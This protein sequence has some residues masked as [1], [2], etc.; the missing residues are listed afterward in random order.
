M[1]TICIPLWDA[2]FFGKM[3]D[4]V[5]AAHRLFSYQKGEEAAVFHKALQAGLLGKQIV[6]GAVFPDFRQVRAQYPAMTREELAET[7]AYEGDRLFRTEEALCMDWAVTEQGPDG[8]DVLAVSVR[9]A[10]LRPWAEAAVAAGR[11]LS[12]VTPLTEAS[13]REGEPV[14][15]CLCGRKSARVY[16]WDGQSWRADRQIALGDAEGLRLFLETAG[17]EALLWFPM[18]DCTEE[19]GRAWERFLRGNDEWRRKETLFLMA[20]LLE[21]RAGLNAAFPEDRPCPFWRGRLRWLRL[22]EGL[23]A[24]AAAVFIGAAAFYGVNAMRCAEA[25]REAARLAPARA[26][27]AAYR[28]EAAARALRNKEQQA[29]AGKDPQWMRRLLLLSDRRPAGIVVK[30]IQAGNESVRITGTAIDGN[31]LSEFQQRLSQAWAIPLRAGTVRKDP[32]L[33]YGE[34]ELRAEEGL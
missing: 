2:V 22:S 12:F 29:F 11:Q 32:A 10:S 5:C 34:F 6:M 23:A 17:T 9:A 3:R 24:A 15:V 14:A 8:Y 30:S 33:P 21:K 28:Q 1:K 19:A 7:M 20:E 25:E 13:A 16:G 26:E 31:A 18:T 27:M 4:G